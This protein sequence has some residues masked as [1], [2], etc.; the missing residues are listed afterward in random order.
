M[1]DVNVKD[2]NKHK[3]RRA[4]NMDFRQSRFEAV[5]IKHEK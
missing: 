2:V 1:G 5:I 4:C 3:E